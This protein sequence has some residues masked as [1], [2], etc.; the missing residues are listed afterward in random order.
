MKKTT[1]K[2]ESSLIKLIKQR[3]KWATA[4][5]ILAVII[6]AA[7]FWTLRYYGEAATYKKR[8][9]ECTAIPGTVSHV[10]NDDCYQDGMLV[11]PL[12]EIEPHEHT[13]ACYTAVL[14]CSLPES[15]GHQHTD[16]CYYTERQLICD[17]EESEE[18]QH[19]NECYAEVNLLV[20]GMEVGELYCLV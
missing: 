2:A 10:H 3:R 15:D 16:A 19:S 12:Q 18:H 6:A 11:C 1:G 17:Q 8:V 4:L 20:C 14:S 5:L 9:L 7:T 13:D